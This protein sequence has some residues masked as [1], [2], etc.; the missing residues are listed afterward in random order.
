MNA[1]HELG[2]IASTRLHMA[3]PVIDLDATVEFYSVIFGLRVLYETKYHG[4]RFVMMSF[5]EHRVSFLECP[6]NVPVT[7]WVSPSGENPLHIGFVV[8]KREDV[9][10]VVLR[11]QGHGFRVA[12]LPREREDVHER[13]MSCVDPNGYQVE[14]YC[15]APYG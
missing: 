14:V 10:R 7:K 2:I 6:E 12:I 13:S 5:G 1:E 3:L 8:E 11:C 9:D 4:R 15:E